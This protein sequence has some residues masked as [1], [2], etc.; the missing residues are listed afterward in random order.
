[1][2][3]ISYLKLVNTKIICVL[4][5]ILSSKYSYA[6]EEIYFMPYEQSQALT[7][8]IKTIS[9]ANERIDIAIYSFTNKEISK[10]LR[11]ISSKG[12]KVN[13]IYDMGQRDTSN[14]TIGYLEKFANI[15]TC[16]LKGNVAKNGKYNG[17]MHQKMII[18][19]NKLIGIG[20]ANWSKSAFESNYETLY[21]T[22]SANII[23][24][25]NEY[26]S[27]MLNLC[28]PFVKY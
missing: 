20:S 16:L 5:L 19:D 18:V 25:A 17:I 14:S 21:F 8:L 2:H 7:K 15:H 12:V 3:R 11:D 1:M 10:A 4:F 24:K 22:D 28:T 6:Y 13:I 27:K 23:E 9:N 26:F